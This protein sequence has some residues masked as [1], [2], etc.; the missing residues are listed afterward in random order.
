L[1]DNLFKG[2]NG[3]N[4][5]EEKT[6]RIILIVVC[7]L[8]GFLGI[9]RFIKKYWISGLIW[10]FTLGLLGVGWILDLI[11]LILEKPFFFAK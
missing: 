3:V 10:V 1:H 8:F 5:M 11:W 6:E 4:I 2:Y 9:Q 7:W